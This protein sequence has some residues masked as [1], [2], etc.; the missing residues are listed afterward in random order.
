VLKGFE[1]YAS[2]RQ[3]DFVLAL[4]GGRARRE[5]LNFLSKL[6]YDSLTDCRSGRGSRI[7][8]L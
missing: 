1:A 3:S 2:G 6:G 5:Y 7:R 4:D 8:R